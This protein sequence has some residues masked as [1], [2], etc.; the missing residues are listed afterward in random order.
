MASLALK[1][2]CHQVVLLTSIMQ[3]TK[4]YYKGMKEIASLGSLLSCSR[5]K[6]GYL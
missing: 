4:P 5:R 6:Y 3:M 1:H 2:L